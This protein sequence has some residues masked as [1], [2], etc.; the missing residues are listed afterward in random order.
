MCIGKG[1]FQDTGRGTCGESR[2]QR[3]RFLGP[4]MALASVGEF[5]AVGEDDDPTGAV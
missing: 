4:E 1:R 5:A 3:A 2:A